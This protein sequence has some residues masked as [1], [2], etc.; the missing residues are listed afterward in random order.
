MAS[1][2]EK[3]EQSGLYMVSGACG[4]A[5][6]RAV[7]RDHLLPHCPICGGRSRWTL[8]REYFAFS[9]HS[10]WSDTV[11]GRAALD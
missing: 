10:V 1:T 3:C 11:N 4:H 8:L 9:Q 6:Q 7:Q 2:G 5:A